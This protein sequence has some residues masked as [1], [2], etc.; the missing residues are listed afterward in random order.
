M[1]GGGDIYST[2]VFDDPKHKVSGPGLERT[3]YSAGTGAFAGTFFG[4]CKAAWYPDPIESVDKKKFAGVPARSD[5]RAVGRTVFRPA[6]WFSLTAGTF[7]AV[8]CAMEAARNDTQ[9]VWNS[10]AAGMAGGAV[11]GM[12]NGR[13]QIIAATAL[14]MGVFM[15]ALDL[16]GPKTVANEAELEYK[17]N[18]WLPKQH[19]E[20]AAV[21]GLKEA[22]PQHKNL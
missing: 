9:D 10:I 1:G 11:I 17:R 20:S 5:F 4:A 21:A 13:P 12:T 22:F 6:M 18:G 7:T 3:L 16:S 15:A 8:E 2:G 14:G 19:V